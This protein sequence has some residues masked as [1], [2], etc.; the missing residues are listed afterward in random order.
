MRIKAGLF[1]I[2]ICL[3]FLSEGQ[4]NELT[5]HLQNASFKAFVD[6]IE[7]KVN[8]KIYYA[9]NWVDSLTID[10][11]SDKQSIDQVLNKALSNSG[12]SFIIVD[13]N[14]IILDRKSVV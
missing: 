2:L 7:K 11:D 13:E 9:N 12:F 3:H 10:I 1:C 4:T 8:F 5:L 14:K 6:S